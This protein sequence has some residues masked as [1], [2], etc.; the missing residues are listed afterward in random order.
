MLVLRSSVSVRRPGLGPLAIRLLWYL[1]CIKPGT[2]EWHDWIVGVNN[3]AVMYRLRGKLI[4][5]LQAMRTSAN[6]VTFRPGPA[7]GYGPLS[8]V[9]DCYFNHSCPSGCWPNSCEKSMCKLFIH[10]ILPYQ[11]QLT[12]DTISTSKIDSELFNN[13]RSSCAL[14]WKWA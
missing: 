3:W 9:I 7:I 11:H 2:L 8:Q 12:A 5:T 13:F 14:Y 6:C 4:L 1:F 10:A